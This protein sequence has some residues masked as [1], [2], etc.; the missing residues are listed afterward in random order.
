MTAR[1]RPP[2]L[3][4]PNPESNGTA[5][6][7]GNG[8][9][10]TPTSTTL[11]QN[12]NHGASS[13]G[14][15]AS[16]YH[17]I[18]FPATPTSTQGGGGGIPNGSLSTSS[19]KIKIGRS[20]RGCYFLSGIWLIGTALMI[21]LIFHVVTGVDKNTRFSNQN[22]VVKYFANDF[23]DFLSS[24]SQERYLT[25]VPLVHLNML[26][27]R[28]SFDMTRQ[29]I[30]KHPNSLTD[31]PSQS[32]A[33]FIQMVKDFPQE[34]VLYDKSPT[35]PASQ[36][37]F[38]TYFCSM[39]LLFSD[40]LGEASTTFVGVDEIVQMQ[41]LATLTLLK[42]YIR[43]LDIIMQVNITHPLYQKQ[44]IIATID[45]LGKVFL[46]SAFLS[47]KNHY[48]QEQPIVMA[49]IVFTYNENPSSIPVAI[50]AML[51]FCDEMIDIVRSSILN[52]AQTDE[53]SSHTL[54]WTTIFALCF[55]AFV[56]V[57]CGCITIIA[58]RKQ[59]LEYQRLLVVDMKHIATLKS[60]AFMELESLRY[61]DD[62]ENPT[63]LESYLGR[64]VK[65]IKYVRSVLP[66]EAP[67]VASPLIHL[68]P[69]FSWS[70]SD[71]REAR[72]P[73]TPLLGSRNRVQSISIQGNTELR[74]FQV[75]ETTMTFVHI[76]WIDDISHVRNLYH[77]R[78]PVSIVTELRER[79]E[80]VEAFAIKYHGVI[81]RI[82]EETITIAFNFKKRLPSHSVKGHYAA[83]SM[84]RTFNEE[85]L[86]T[87]PMTV[88]VAAHTSL[89]LVGVVGTER[90]QG[91]V[92]YCRDMH[93]VRTMHS[94]S[95]EHRCVVT[96]PGILSIQQHFTIEPVLGASVSGDWPDSVDP[97]DS[98]LYKLLDIVE[99]L[100]PTSPHSPMTPGTP[101]T[102]LTHE[103]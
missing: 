64:I 19:S 67:Q 91:M 9:L 37:R 52:S 63:E 12:V 21:S 87:S 98:Y 60:I 68:K 3:S 66:Q 40:L 1:A 73:G 23:F 76:T 56:A 45:T 7:H 92:I 80:R 48:L 8:D 29:E 17:R 30:L 71:L 2:N 24:S 72:K 43:I 57:F 53:K 51:D 65:M 15:P 36:I 11:M 47:A 62:L 10:T 5:V 38:F 89:G 14:S 58:L 50:P 93:L 39:N 95:M 16:K 26:E 4:I 55:G 84:F 100:T 22:D 82:T 20:F 85:G 99:G 97:A 33:T 59:N 42:E 46:R 35:N 44:V 54:M 88:A 27:A 77:E 69:N 28:V 86:G 81:I 18:T 74:G 96:T 32:W 61:L 83:I 78:G 79:I 90:V 34:R 13:G 6:E 49:R 94:I 25:F 70:S 102:A 31:P 103:I 101:A 41:S 75:T